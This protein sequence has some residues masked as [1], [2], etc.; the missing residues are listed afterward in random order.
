MSGYVQIHLV[1]NAA[2]SRIS[3]YFVSKQKKN[4]PSRGEWVHL[5]Y[6]R[7]C[8]CMWWW[9]LLCYSEWGASSSV[10]HPQAQEY[11]E[12]TCS[13]FLCSPSLHSP[14]LTSHK[15]WDW[16]E[17]GCAVCV[18]LCAC[19]HVRQWDEWRWSGVYNSRTAKETLYLFKC[20]NLKD[21][22]VEHN[23]VFALLSPF[24]TY[25]VYLAVFHRM[26]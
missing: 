2:L 26:M 6:V 21:L 23:S 20:L 8:I 25:Q 10:I 16:S 18:S 13:T 1:Q 17:V 11:K 9:R 14:L 19:T 7:P 15:Q 12:A 22:S 5:L 24:T 3:N 4:H